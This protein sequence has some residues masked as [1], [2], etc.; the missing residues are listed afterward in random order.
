MPTEERL[1]RP[2][3]R[4]LIG[5]AAFVALCLLVSGLG[6]AITATS[7]STWYQELEK[8]AFNPPDWIF[9]PVWT[10]LYLCMAVAAWRVWRKGTTAAS[11]RALMVF[12][13]QL[14][15][16]LGWSFLFFGLRRI[17]LA[18]A[19]IFV[20]LAAIAVNT[21]LLWRLDKTAG[22]LFMPY[23]AWVAFA[24]L[25]TASLWRLNGA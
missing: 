8:P 22:L 23:F 3:R 17:D 21:V 4:D 9:A 20:L 5:L 10:L 18:L 15:L 6:G 13:V 7:V 24:C 1:V 2:S 25:L 16:N 11:R 14:G 19:E 12:A